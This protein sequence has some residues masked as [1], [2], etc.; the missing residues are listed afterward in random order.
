MF[1]TTETIVCKCFSLIILPA[2]HTIT[3]LFE[4]VGFRVLCACNSNHMEG[5]LG[6]AK[7]LVTYTELIF[8]HGVTFCY[9]DPALLIEPVHLLD[10][11]TIHSSICLAHGFV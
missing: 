6:T 7:F 3:F 4:L 8:I 2:S 10:L 5:Q 1:V 11:W 9:F